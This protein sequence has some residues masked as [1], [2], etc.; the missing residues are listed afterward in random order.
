MSESAKFRGDPL[1]PKELRH[2]L[3]GEESVRKMARVSARSLP[4]PS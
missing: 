3:D 4:R 1:Q 2:T